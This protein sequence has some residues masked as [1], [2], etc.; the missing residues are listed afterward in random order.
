MVELGGVSRR[1]FYRFRAR[2]EPG[3]GRDMDPATA[4]VCRHLATAMALTGVDQLWR[5]D[6]TYIRLREEFVLL[7]VILAAFSAK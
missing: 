6:I 5:A 2:P 1:S 7:A 4:Y 3:P